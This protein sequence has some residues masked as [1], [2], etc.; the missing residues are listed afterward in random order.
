MIYLQPSLGNAL[1]LLVIWTISIIMAA[2]ISTKTAMAFLLGVI[3]TLSYFQLSI[4][5]YIAEA[6][7]LNELF[8]KIFTLAALAAIFITLYFLFKF[9]K[10]LLVCV[11]AAIIAIAPVTELGWNNI[12]KDYH[13]E[14]IESF[15][16]GFSNDPQGTNY[17][18]RQSI[19]AIGAGQLRGRGYLQGTQSTLK[20]LP[21]AHTDFIFAALAEQFGFIGVATLFIIYGIL[22]ARILFISIKTK[23]KFGKI[24]VIGVLSIV[25]VNILVNTAMN[26]GLAPVTGVPLPLISYGGSSVIVIMISLGLVQTV[27]SAVDSRSV[28]FML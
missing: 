8:W 17:Q 12:L 20:T 2:P 24:L 26:L 18:I 6:S 21:F 25:I 15:T 27:N 9:N 14:R 7:F 19:I 22:I 10:Y 5:S 4:F 1:I 23:N 3:T 13:R 16:Q 28:A 11:F